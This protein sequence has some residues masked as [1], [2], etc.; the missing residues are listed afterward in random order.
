MTI[1]RS[2]PARVSPSP[3]SDSNLIELS[4]LMCSLELNG[5]IS[6]PIRSDWLFLTLLKA[7]ISRWLISR[8]WN[9]L[10]RRTKCFKFFIF[11]NASKLIGCRSILFE[12]IS[13]SLRWHINSKQSRKHDWTGTTR[14]I[15]DELMIYFLEALLP[16]YRSIIVKVE[17]SFSSRKLQNGH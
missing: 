9:Y 13:H 2:L 1:W 11:F 15:L 7:L 14:S 17:I 8:G 12:V 16:I 5:L 3:R 4:H 10:Y 6:R